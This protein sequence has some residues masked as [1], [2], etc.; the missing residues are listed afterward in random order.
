MAHSRRNGSDVFVRALYSYNGSES[1]LSFRQG[2]VIQVIT[3]LETGWWDGIVLQS[4]VRGWFPSNYVEP[5]TEAE[6]LWTAR[7]PDSRPRQQQRTVSRDSALVDDDEFT[8]VLGDLIS[9]GERRNNDPLPDFMLEREIDAFSTGGD[10]FSEIAAAA[11]A[12]RTSVSH[13]STRSTSPEEGLPS[14]IGRQARKP[15]DGDFFFVGRAPRE[16]I[17]PGPRLS[18]RLSAIQLHDRPLPPD[19]A[20]NVGAY[21]PESERDA[22]S[23]PSDDSDDSD[24]DIGFPTFVGR[25][26]KASDFGVTRDFARKLDF[27]TVPAS[28]VPAQLEEQPP[29]LLAALERNVRSALAALVHSAT[30]APDDQSDATPSRVNV[31]DLGSSAILELRSLLRASAVFASGGSGAMDRSASLE[32]RRLIA[33]VSRLSFALRLLGRPHPSL[34]GKDAD[35][36]SGDGRADASAGSRP[37]SPKGHEPDSKPLL[38]VLREAQAV[39]KSLSTRAAGVVSTLTGLRSL[40]PPLDEDAVDQALKAQQDL[41]ELLALVDN[42]AV[43]PPK[44]WQND[45]DCVDSRA[46]PLAEINILRRNLL[47]VVPQILFGGVGVTKEAPAQVSGVPEEHLEAPASDAYPSDDVDSATD[48]PIGTIV[49]RAMRDVQALAP[50]LAALLP[51]DVEVMADAAEDPPE[52]RTSDPIVSL[53]TPTSSAA[54]VDT[55]PSQDDISRVHS[56]ATSTR[57]SVDS[58]FFFSGSA[59][60][61]DSFRSSA[62]TRDSY[63]GGG[64]SSASSGSGVEVLRPPPTV[65]PGWDSGRRGSSATWS[66]TSS[67]ALPS[68]QNGSFASTDGHRNSTRSSS[69][70]IHKLLGEVPPEAVV[71]ESAPSGPWYLARDWDDEELSFTMEH[72]VRGGTL[73]G[74]VIAAT[75]HEGRVDSSYLSAF[76]MTYRTF[77]TS[78]QLLDELIER[79]NVLEPEGLDA[80]E[81]KEWESR[82]QRPIRARVT[83]LLKAWVRE[84]MDAEDLDRD[85]LERIRQ[86]ALTTMTEKGQALQICKSVDERMQG[87]ARRP[88][89]NLAPGSFPP[90]IVPRNLKK[91]RL[92]D[93]E[94]LELARQLTIMDSR[95]FQ[96]ITAQ[97][98]LSKAWSKQFNT[99]APNITAMIDMSNAVTRWVTFSILAQD[100]LKKRAN[101]IKHF[102]A[103]AERCLSLNNF[104]VLIHIIAGLNST[105][106]HRLRRTWETVN[107]KTMITLG[108]LNRVMKPDKNYKEYRA[109]LRKSAPPCVPFLGVYLTDWTF[110]GD[111]NSDMLREKPDQINFHKRQKASELILMIKLHQATTY[112]LQAVPPIATFLQDSLFPPAL[113]TSREDQRLY[114]MSLALEPREREDEKI[115]RLLSESGFL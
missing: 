14:P 62:I 12:E 29:P 91:L 49:D 54:G 11:R 80:N 9:I 94:P 57:D 35:D 37:A 102:V 33:A 100:D 77:C 95:L 61:I 90:P 92:M 108:M 58:S 23:S 73:R 74:L 30:S 50:M 110:I 93:I 75:S 89:G 2:D 22:P 113:E 71:R 39:D 43:E 82:K 78:H 67:S 34:Y 13:P 32:S 8:G 25:A 97:E 84:Y 18:D 42:V 24:L 7:L 45:L 20:G 19:G 103:V 88:I 17:Q 87:A 15:S 48:W 5:V 27:P 56:S 104:S 66:T 46:A 26:P 40:V 76:L 47:K 106:I 44:D 21:P 10:I 79:Y 4:G 60:G 98:C 52:R 51:P 70:N 72:T 53:G 114:E 3:T 105:P 96:R 28:S 55:T 85:L 81:H 1:S 64:E 41:V 65:P 107:Q 111:G 109:I 31:L 68:P 38:E 6:A 86:F 16:S 101:V 115:A 36:Q 69:K 112:N 63:F 83:N 99:D 59:F